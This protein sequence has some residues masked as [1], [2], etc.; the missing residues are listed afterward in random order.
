M[1]MHFSD[2]SLVGLRLTTSLNTY[3]SRAAVRN[4]S[5]R[6]FEEFCHCSFRVMDLE[7]HTSRGETR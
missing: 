1:K 3:S 6:L 7:M 2:S 5:D 4:H